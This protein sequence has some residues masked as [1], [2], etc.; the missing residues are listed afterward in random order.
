MILL[1]KFS[2]YFHPFQ[3]V[4]SH[5][6]VIGPD[7]EGNLRIDRIVEPMSEHIDVI[8]F[9]ENILIL[10]AFKILAEKPFGCQNCGKSF[11]LKSYLAKHQNA[12]V[13]HKEAKKLAKNE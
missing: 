1:L 5:L 3:P 9:I 13:C 8:K 12:M 10:T 4:R 11:K 6:N 7:A 2:N